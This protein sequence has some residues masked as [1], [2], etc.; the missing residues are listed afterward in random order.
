MNDDNVVGTVARRLGAALGVLLSVMGLLVVAAPQASADTGAGDLPVAQTLGGRELTVVLRR[1]AEVPGPLEVDILTHTG[2]P[3]G[4]LRLSAV[5][6]GVSVGASGAPAGTPAD[7]AVVALGS[8]P[9][10]YSA[11]LGIQ[12][13]GP[14]ELRL[15]DGQHTARI[16][17]VAQGQVASPPELAVYGGFIAAGV[18]IPVTALVAVRA[19]RG[20]WVLLPA[21][22]AVAALAV[23]VTA[24]LLSASFPLPPDPGRQID[25]TVDNVTDPY[26]AI[27]PT[28]ADYSRPPATLLLRLSSVDGDG[29]AD[30]GLTLTDGSTGLP[31][32]D[33]VVHD[34]AL[35][36]LL[37]V[38]PSGQLQHLHPVMTGPG[39]FDVAVRLAEA[40]HYAVSAEV[41]RRGG[42]V[43]QLR[44]AT[45]LDIASG[46][47][48]AEPS[49]S[50]GLG[51][52]TVDG[53][54]VQLSAPSLTAG[55]ATVLTTRVGDSA[56][57]QPWLGMLGHLIVVGP[58]PSDAT[59]VG[60]AAQTAE[61][62]A[63][64]HSMGGMGAMAGMDMGAGST[65]SSG[66]MNGLMPANGDSVIDETV[67]AYGPDVSFVYTFP[68]PGNYRVWIQA[69]RNSTILT[70]P[71]LLYVRGSS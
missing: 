51:S 70:I 17:F 5:P 60:E 68:A 47:A 61:V 42:G 11:V 50:G 16:P 30:L 71:A 49:Q 15:D 13:P 53:V 35:M 58:L 48:S 26:G 19:R 56:T 20:S 62:W 27:R 18:L 8:T 59:R 34:G 29:T 41:A 65:D 10:S 9:S 54:Q 44:S 43:Q 57:L 12:R 21:G 3:G 69:E 40:G 46:S 66:T 22:G 31:V 28:I 6:T 25:P 7:S 24:A 67:A 32:D 1:L 63:H 14:W 45:G 39:A 33:L 36:H 23:A 52:R 64:S 4:Q 37:V 38:G 2:A 55:T